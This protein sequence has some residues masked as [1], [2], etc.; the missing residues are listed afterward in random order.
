MRQFDPWA[1]GLSYHNGAL[2]FYVQSL[3]AVPLQAN[4]QGTN[5]ITPGGLRPDSNQSSSNRR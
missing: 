1:C 4:T 5:A 2:F 3:S